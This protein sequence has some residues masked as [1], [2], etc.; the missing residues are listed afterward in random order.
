LRAGGETVVDVLRHALPEAR[1]VPRV[2]SHCRFRKRG[3]DYLGESGIK[4][5]SGITKRQC[6]RTLGIP[7]R[8]I[9]RR[10][11]CSDGVGH[12]CAEATPRGRRQAGGTRS[13]SGQG[14]TRRTAR[15]KN[16][17]DSLGVPPCHVRMSR[18]IAVL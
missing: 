12:V 14:G 16:G 8:E 11:H 5:M 2:R 9:V 13:S 7:R 3:I 15:R 1:V 4:Q 18:M 10:G 6:D 17:G